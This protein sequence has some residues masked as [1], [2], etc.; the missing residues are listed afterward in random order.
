MNELSL[1]GK[2]LQPDGFAAA[3]LKRVDKTSQVH[4]FGIGNYWSPGN[5][6]TNMYRHVDN[7]VYSVPDFSVL[8]KS[9]VFF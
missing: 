4:W 2:S 7:L 9:L 5:R 3:G 8:K 6:V 1:P